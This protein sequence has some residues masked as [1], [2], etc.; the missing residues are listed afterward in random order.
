MLLYRIISLSIFAQ[1][2]IIT[3]S[4]QSMTNANNPEQT[5]QDCAQP[6][7]AY[8]QPDLMPPTKQ[9][10]LDTVSQYFYYCN[11]KYEHYHVMHGNAANTTIIALS[12]NGKHI[13]TAV[14]RTIKLWSIENGDQAALRS[15]TD[16]ITALTISPR[17]KYL[18]SGSKNGGI[19]VWERETETLLYT[20]NNQNEKASPFFQS[21]SALTFS[22]DEKLLVSTSVQQ[23]IVLWKVET[24]EKIKQ[25]ELNEFHAPTELA[26]SNDGVYLAYLIPNNGKKILNLQ[27]EKTLPPEEIK[28][29]F[30]CLFPSFNNRSSKKLCAINPQSGSHIHLDTEDFDLYEKNKLHLI[31]NLPLTNIKKPIIA[32]LSRDGSTIGYIKND[33]LHIL[34]YSNTPVDFSICSEKLL[35]LLYTIATYKL[36]K[37]QLTL[38]ESN[39][40]L[41]LPD[42][43]LSS[44]KKIL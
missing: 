40:L 18:A 34:K 25:F 10:L 36:D 30:Y 24:G 23:E 32:T 27:T 22:Q 13:A 9:E 37:K 43:L 33:R 2:I 35:D 26:L 39:L 21:T 16:N 1:L 14:G 20:I 8:P 38:E 42:F 5:Q 12:D 28:D 31:F 19:S 11:E 29:L 7:I 44:I 41:T 17:G 4:L 15:H 3:T 6:I